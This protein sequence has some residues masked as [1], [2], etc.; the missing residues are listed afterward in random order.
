MWKRAVRRRPSGSAAQRVEGPSVNLLPRIGGA[1][2]EQTRRALIRTIAPILSS[3]SRIVSTCASALCRRLHGRGNRCHRHHPPANVLGPRRLQ[4]HCPRGTHLVLRWSVSS[5]RLLNKGQPPCRHAP[6]VAFRRRCDYGYL[7][8]FSSSFSSSIIPISITRTI[9]VR[10]GGWK[11]IR[12]PAGS[13]RP[14]ASGQGRH[15]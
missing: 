11:S 5:W 14:A 9:G 2:L 4:R 7:V 6:V 10:C 13:R 1:E 12:P 8:S 3:L 15:R